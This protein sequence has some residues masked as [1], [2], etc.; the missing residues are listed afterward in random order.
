VPA[1]A[2]PVDGITVPNRFAIGPDVNLCG[3]A[4]DELSTVITRTISLDAAKGVNVALP[5]S[6]R[7][8]D[9]PLPGCLSSNDIP[10]V[11]WR[12]RPRHQ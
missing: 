9:F 1:L 11:R 12:H 8:P 5:R 10:T 6:R 7:R 4:F 3:E 2:T